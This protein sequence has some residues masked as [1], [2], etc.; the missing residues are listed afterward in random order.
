MPEPAT[1]RDVMPPLLT[2]LEGNRGAP[3]AEAIGFELLI[4]D[5][6]TSAELRDAYAGKLCVWGCAGRAAQVRAEAAKIRAG[7][8]VSRRRY[9]P[10]LVIHCPAGLTNMGTDAAPD[11]RLNADIAGEVMEQWRESGGALLLPAVLDAAGHPLWR[12]EVMPEHEF[13]WAYTIAPSSEVAVP[14]P[15]VG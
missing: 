9:L 5:D 7:E 14:A 2:V 4:A 13:A 10:P 12:I 3:V 15:A 11:L 8:K 6:T 1:L